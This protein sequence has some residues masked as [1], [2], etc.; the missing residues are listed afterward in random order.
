MNIKDT[1]N[2]VNNVFAKLPFKG[3]AEKIPAEKR[4]KVPVLENSYHG[5]TKLSAALRW[6]WL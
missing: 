4:A 1:L 2:N 5:Q 6:F 3:F